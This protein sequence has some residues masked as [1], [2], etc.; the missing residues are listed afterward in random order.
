MEGAGTHRRAADRGARPQ[1]FGGSAVG[2][3]ADQPDARGARAAYRGPAGFSANRRADAA[4]H[5]AGAVPCPDGVEERE[6]C[7]QIKT[8]RE[9]A[10]WSGSK[11][12]VRCGPSSTAGLRK[13]ATRWT[14][15]AR[16]RW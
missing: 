14:P 1:A 10:K 8:V 11:S 12:R 3:A 6:G 9:E 16:T 2:G 5:D 13:R 4:S 7:T 15:T